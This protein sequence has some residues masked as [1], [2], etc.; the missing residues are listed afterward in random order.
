MS[1]Q[2]WFYTDLKIIDLTNKKGAPPSEINSQ[3]NTH[4]YTSSHMNIFTTHYF[5]SKHYHTYF[6]AHTH[7][8]FLKDYSRI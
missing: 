2:F 7:S 5:P 4:L 8:P 3:T 6:L 1:F